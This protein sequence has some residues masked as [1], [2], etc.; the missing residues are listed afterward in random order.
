MN[1]REKRQQSSLAEIFPNGSVVILHPGC[2]AAMFS[3]PAFP[4]P[5]PA[6]P[7]D[8]RYGM[9][10]CL[11]LDACRVLTNYA[12]K[13]NRDFFARDRAGKELVRIQVDRIDLLHPGCYYYFL[14]SSETPA[15]VK[16][17]IVKTFASLTFPHPIP[18][19]WSRAV[20]S[21]S[22]AKSLLVMARDRCQTP[23]TSYDPSF[24]NDIGAFV[25][26]AEV[27]WF[28]ANEMYRYSADAAAGPANDPANWTTLRTD[29]IDIFYKHAF[30]FYPTGDGEHFVYFLDT[31][32]LSYAAEYHRRRVNL[33]AEVADP[34]VYA[35]FAYAVVNLPRCDDLFEGL[36]VGDAV[37]LARNHRMLR[38]AYTSRPIP[39]WI[40][41]MDPQ[42]KQLCE[43]FA[44]SL[45]P[46]FL[47]TLQGSGENEGTGEEVQTA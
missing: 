27:D 24:T 31:A 40:Q 1:R 35:R 3:L 30:V 2:D 15:N 7:T 9:P 41:K 32:H 47:A 6:N 19:H 36:A 46:E 34:F 17:P 13:D 39:E 29:I 44:V 42:L 10:S 22:S 11:V 4:Q 33:H 38:E 8:K 28:N 23:N 14:G 26:P 45:G 25:P 43:A 16:Y 5:N 20:T 18:R 37:R 21:T 12:A